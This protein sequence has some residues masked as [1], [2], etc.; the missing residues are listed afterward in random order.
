[1]IAGH[2][3]AVAATWSL[4]TRTRLPW[5]V[6]AA[7]GPDILDLAYVLLGICSPS[8]LYSHT[9]PAAVLLASVLAGAALLAEDRATAA[10]VFVLVLAH[11]PFDWP[12]GQKLFWPGGEIHGLGWYRW[13]LRDFLV[14]AASIAAGWLLLVRAEPRNWRRWTIAF[15]LA[16]LASQA[17]IDMSGALR[18]PSAC[19]ERP[20]HG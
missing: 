12:T 11:L 17:A 2:L 19:T 5:L 15:G 20:E 13:P 10:M 9:L 7:F 6:I 1:M 3:G 16:A 18:K 4:R 8:G 14:E